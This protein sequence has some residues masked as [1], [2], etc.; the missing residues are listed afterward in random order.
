M[1]GRCAARAGRDLARRD[2]A[3]SLSLLGTADS[4]MAATHAQGGARFQP[5]ENR[6][7]RVL[8]SPLSLS[9]EPTASRTRHTHRRCAARAGRDPAGRN[10]SPFLCSAQPTV[11]G[12]QHAHSAVR[13]PLA[14]RLVPA[15]RGLARPILLLGTADSVMVVTPAQPVRGPGR[16]RPG[17]EESF[18]LPFSAR[19]SRQ[20]Q[21][22]DTSTGAVRGPSR[23]RPCGEGSRP[24][25]LAARH[26]SRN[27]AASPT[28]PPD[29]AVET[30]GGRVQ[31]RG[32]RR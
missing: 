29:A 16:A 21:G 1:H 30:A 32:V 25:P 3:P 5:G 23:A 10:L 24:L 7:G 8:S 11:S 12:P 18:S 26:R 20:C 4:S 15:R 9:A 2:P 22:R 14:S 13:G 6:R 27:W 17:R 28:E 19:H 31:R